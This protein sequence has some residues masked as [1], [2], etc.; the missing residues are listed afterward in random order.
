MDTR[1]CGFLVLGPLL[2]ALVIDSHSLWTD[3]PRVFVLLSITFSL[4]ASFNLEYPFTANS[5]LYFRI[6][7]FATLCVG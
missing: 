5:L 4:S 6:N 1:A 7:S 2:Y 3:P